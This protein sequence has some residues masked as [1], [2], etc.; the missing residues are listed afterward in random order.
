[1]GGIISDVMQLEQVGSPPVGCQDV[2]QLAGTIAGRAS[3]L[4]GISGE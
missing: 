1:M 3:E 2:D 4:R